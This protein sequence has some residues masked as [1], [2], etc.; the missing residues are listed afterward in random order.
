MNVRFLEGHPVFYWSCIE[1]LLTWKDKF[2]AEGGVEVLNVNVEPV[3]CLAE[4]G[5]WGV[6]SVWC[7]VF[8]C[9]VERWRSDDWTVYVAFSCLQ[10]VL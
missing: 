9:P 10:S 8:T 4:R 6:V 7:H 2:G 3:E 5:P 1:G